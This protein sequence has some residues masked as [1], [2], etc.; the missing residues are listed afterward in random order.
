[1]SDLDNKTLSPAEETAVSEERDDSKDYTTPKRSRANIM[2][3]ILCLLLATALWGF[4]IQNRNPN[5]TKTLECLPITVKGVPEG[6]HTTL[7][8][9]CVTLTLSGPREQLDD[10]TADQVAVYVDC[11]A[12]SGTAGGY[13]LPLLA[14]LPSG[15]AIN[16]ALGF[17]QVEI[18]QE[19]PAAGEGAGT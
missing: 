17:V 2:V 4:V 7:S 1:M 14:D 16:A 19:T 6:Y 11:S 5:V 18:A 12:L 15:V 10:L 9:D 8:M 13:T 3:A